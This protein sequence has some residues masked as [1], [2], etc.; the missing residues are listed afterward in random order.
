MTALMFIIVAYFMYC[1]LDL[2]GSLTSLDHHA[3]F[4]PVIE[5]TTLEQLKRKQN[6][7]QVSGFLAN[8]FNYFNLSQD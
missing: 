5:V 4:N 1:D 6:N 8:Q 2:A 3:A 7:D